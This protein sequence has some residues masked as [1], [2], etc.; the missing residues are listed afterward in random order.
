MAE[1]K[2]L[3]PVIAGGA[4]VLS[5]IGVYVNLLHW[6]VADKTD[7]F[8]IA[9]QIAVLILGISLTAW[10][11]YSNLKDANRA[12]PLHAEIVAVK[13]EAKIQ[14]DGA[15][16]LHSEELRRLEVSH[17][18]ELSSAKEVRRQ[19]QIE[20]QVALTRVSDLEEKLALSAPSSKLVIHAAYYGNTPENELSVI[21]RVNEAVRDALAIQVNNNVL[22]CDPAPNI[23]PRKRLR[24]KYSYGTGTIFEASCIEGEWLVLPENTELRKLLKSDR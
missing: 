15:E 11:V 2:N 4:L 21:G 7:Y 12:K 10:A 14:I 16:K 18:D 17:K 1:N 5:G 20:R 13:E 6:R 8:P 22:G 24:V 3:G 23:A 9:V 19:C